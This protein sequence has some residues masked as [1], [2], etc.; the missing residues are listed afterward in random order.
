MFVLAF[1]SPSAILR[2]AQLGRIRLHLVTEMRPGSESTPQPANPIITG[3]DRRSKVS[4]HQLCVKD[5]I[6]HIECDLRHTMCLYYM[7]W[8]K[9]R[10]PACA[11][12][13]SYG[14]I[15]TPWYVVYKIAWELEGKKEPKPLTLQERLHPK[16]FRGACQSHTKSKTRAFLKNLLNFNPIHTYTWGHSWSWAKSPPSLTNT[17]TQLFKM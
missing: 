8:T 12:N 17:H 9:H 1:F 15:Y 6:Q 5:L 3:S 7:L 4:L 13:I 11:V 16:A 14:S 2:A 10:R